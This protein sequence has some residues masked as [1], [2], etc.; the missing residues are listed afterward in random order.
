LHRRGHAAQSLS[1]A[2]DELAIYWAKGGAPAA[3]PLR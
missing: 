1:N 3:A 2:R